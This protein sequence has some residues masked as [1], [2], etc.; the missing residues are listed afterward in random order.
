MTMRAG[1]AALM[2]S[3]LWHSGGAN[4]SSQRRCLLVVSFGDGANLPDG[5][6]YSILPQL[7]RKHTLRSL[8]DAKRC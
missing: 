7:A 8:R 3:R 6:T 5:S 4:S 1:D 2:D